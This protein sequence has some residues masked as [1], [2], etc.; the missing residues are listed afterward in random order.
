MSSMTQQAT[1]WPGQSHGLS[2]REGEVLALI[3]QGLSNEQIA[4]RAF[5]SP[6]TVKSYIRS[7]YRKIDV[8]TRT[9]AVIWALSN[10]IACDE[11]GPAPEV[12]EAG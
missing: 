8:T 5:L 6:N 7:A 2:P 11:P 1:D 12:R 4:A 10:D 3:A 9:H